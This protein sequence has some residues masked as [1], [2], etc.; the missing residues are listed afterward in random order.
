MYLLEVSK[1]SNIEK[2]GKE[3]IESKGEK[4]KEQKQ[5]RT[6]GGIQQGEWR[7]HVL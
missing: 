7:I 5:V 3:I 2:R 4:M 6:G 1:N